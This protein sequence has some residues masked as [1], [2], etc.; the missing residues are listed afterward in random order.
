MLK[1]GCA[2]NDHFHRPPW[3]IRNVITKFKVASTIILRS[4]TFNTFLKG[5]TAHFANRN[6]G[7]YPVSSSQRISFERNPTTYIIKHLT[8]PPDPILPDLTQFN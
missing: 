8:T 5:H 7:T 1:Y 6:L 4:W 3:K 2:R